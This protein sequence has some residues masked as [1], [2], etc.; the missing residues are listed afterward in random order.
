MTDKIDEQLKPLYLELSKAGPSQ[1]WE[2]ILKIAKKILEVSPA[3]EKAFQ[4]K[5]VCLIHLDKFEEAITSIDEYGKVNMTFEKAYCEYRLNRIDRA[6]ST[7]Q[8][9]K[10]LGIKE[11]E[12]LAQITYK[13][14]KYQE[15]Y[16]N[17]REVVK[18]AD[19]DFDTERQTNLSAVV[20]AMRLANPTG[21][22]ELDM[23]ENERKTYELCYNSAC[24][25]IGKGNFKEA[26]L[27]LERAEK[28]CRET[29]EDDPED[30]EVLE[31]EVAIIRIQLAYCL[32]KLGKFDD[33]NEIY[34][35]FL[36]TRPTDLSI[37]AVVS[38]N[39][40]CLNK[41]RN[42]FDSKKRLK[43]ATGSGL[44]LKLNSIQKKLIAFNEILFSMISNQNEAAKKLLATFDSKFNDRER[45]VLLQVYQLFREKRLAQLQTKKLD[46][47]S[48]EA[49]F[50]LLTLKSNTGKK[51]EKS[52][53]TSVKIPPPATTTTVSS[54]KSSKQGAIKSPTTSTATT[55]TTTATTTA[56]K[57]VKKKRKVILPKNFDPTATID[58]ERWL[59]LRERSY[60]RG[61][62]NNKKK[63]QAVGKGTQGA[64]SSDTPQ[65]PKAGASSSANQQPDK[66]MPAG[67]KP[68]SSGPAK[69]NNKKKGGKW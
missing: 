34:N 15:S 3:E 47:P 25:S 37:I 45:L 27:K 59:P 67:V 6:Y 9:A 60:Y 7:L 66:P 51:S 43:M 13:L 19:D 21:A 40:V 50:A 14:E 26:K 2:K 64:V 33:A 49:K 16:D 11:R 58:P 41:N 8:N 68:K 17:Y 28:M 29:F 5:I 53:T 10:P 61:R 20:A 63:N 39:L 4:V 56:A 12:L 44:E 54:A 36:A 31:N 46:L 57:V 23:T 52:K 55:T 65:S 24:I 35:N 38:N 69:K 48:L 62:R 30:K 32:Q 42:L 1:D 22:K 18:N